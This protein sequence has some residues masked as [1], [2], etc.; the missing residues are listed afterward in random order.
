M[1]L[2]IA[3]EAQRHAGARLGL[4]ANHFRLQMKRFFAGQ[5][6]IE[7]GR[8]AGLELARRSHEEPVA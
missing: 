1:P 8:S 3:D 7:L 2:D 4:H 5:I 6:E